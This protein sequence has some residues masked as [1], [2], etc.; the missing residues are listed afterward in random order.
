[1]K[2]FGTEKI[3]EEL[4][5]IFPQAR[6]ARMDLDSTRTRFAHQKLIN[7]FEEH[8]IDI[9]VGTQMVTKGL[10]FDRV[11]LVGILNADNLLSYPDFRSFE[12]GFQMMAQVAGRAGRKN[13]QGTVLIQAYNVS[14]P[15]L[16]MVK[17]NDYAQMYNSQIDE[18]QRFAYPP[19]FR[20]IEL[21]LQHPNADLINKAADELTRSLRGIFGER[22]LGPEY[23]MVSRIKNQ[24]LKRILIKLEKGIALSKA[25]TEMLQCI[26]NIRAKKGFSTVRVL[27]DV[28]PA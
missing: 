7:T 21:T 22:V 23:P 20:L 8:K 2:G 15:A 12:R 26:T 27:I 5:L 6:I 1:M 16:Q 14:H 3:E 24:F 13:K 4:S 17:A 28:D 25:K 10:D 19:F 11:S 18:R 9:L